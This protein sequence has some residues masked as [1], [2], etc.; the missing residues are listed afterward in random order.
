MK[1]A[2]HSKILELISERMITTQEELTELLS[3]EGFAVTQATVSRDIKELRLIK[4]Q[5]P[6]GRYRYAP[7]AADQ[8]VSGM[9]SFCML[10]SQSLLHVDYADNIVVIKCRTGMAN[11]VCVSMDRCV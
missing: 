4:L 9:D 10:L 2:R 7:A 1:T 6:D 3:K 5:G 8:Q 11:A